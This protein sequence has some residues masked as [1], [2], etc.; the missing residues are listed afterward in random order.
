MAR[1]NTAASWMDEKGIVRGFTNTGGMPRYVSTPYLYQIAEDNIPGHK[2]WLKLGYNASVDTAAEEDIWDYGGAYVFPTA[3]MQME[4]VGGA[5]DTAAGTGIQQ[6]MIVY[7][8]GNYME[9]TEIVT[10]DATTPVNTRATDIFRINAL[11]AYRVGTAGVAAGSV[12]I[13]ETDAS[14]VFS[15][16]ALG[17]TRA[18]TATYTVPQGKTLYVT[19]ANFSA[20]GATTSKS[21]VITVLATYDEL[22]EKRTDFFMPMAEIGLTDN[23][24]ALCF[25]IP[26]KFPERTDIRVIGTAASNTN[27]VTSA[28]RG[29]LEDNQW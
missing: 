14:P 2:H 13:S 25:D 12:D 3:P 22:R 19:N 10:M 9:K 6:V 28:M 21:V 20:N 5:Q 26:L 11:H 1:I 7:L 17:H 8:D 29:W 18:R 23:H 24:A 4:V 15:R 16:I 27:I